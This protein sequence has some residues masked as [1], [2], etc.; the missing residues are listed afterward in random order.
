[1]GKCADDKGR[2]SIEGMSKGRI[3][4]EIMKLQKEKDNAI[5]CFLECLVKAKPAKT[6][7]IDPNGTATTRRPLKEVVLQD[8]DGQ[9]LNHDQ[10]CGPL[11]CLVDDFLKPRPRINE[12]D[13][14][15]EYEYPEH[16]PEMRTEMMQRNDVS[17]LEDDGCRDRRTIGCFF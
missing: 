17:D 7:I 15:Y 3:I 11:G 1:M 2:N 8:S 13:D 10:S 5:D 9:V 16:H 14:Y 4:K 12:V 6:V